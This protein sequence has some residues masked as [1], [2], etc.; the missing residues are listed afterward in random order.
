MEQ[1]QK[2]VKLEQSNNKE[3][4]L[5]ILP[6]LK[7]QWKVWETKS[8]GFPS[9]KNKNKKTWNGKN[10]ATRVN[11]KGPMSNSIA[12]QNKTKRKSI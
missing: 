11:A 12:F 5:E 4:L 10:K 2:A 7:L 9:I 6:K 3:K 8:R 1:K